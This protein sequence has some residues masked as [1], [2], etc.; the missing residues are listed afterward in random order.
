MRITSCHGL[1]K[2]P[3]VAWHNPQT[4]ACLFLMEWRSPLP[5]QILEEIEVT[6]PEQ[7]GN[8]YIV[9]AVSYE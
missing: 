1:P 9:G 8:V 2:S 6:W 4:D 3:G 5:D 7:S